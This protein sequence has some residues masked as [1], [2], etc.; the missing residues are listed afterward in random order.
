MTI[1]L[2]VFDDQVETG[3]SFDREEGRTDQSFKEDC[4]VRSI[5]Q[6]AARTGFLP[7]RDPAE[8]RYI[9]CVGIPSFQEARELVRQVEA[10]FLALPP[11]IRRECDGDPAVF[12][13]RLEDPEFVDELVRAGLAKRRESS[14]PPD[15]AGSEA[16]SESAE[17]PGEEA[18]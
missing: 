9:N 6:R 18:S 2:R 17:P 10:E 1:K 5:V 8:A 7:G 3:R 12:V 13:R 4:D 11:R 14:P 16:A 15:G